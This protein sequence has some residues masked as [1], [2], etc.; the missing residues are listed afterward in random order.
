MD[1]PVAENTSSPG[2]PLP[3]AGES[4]WNRSSQKIDI[5]KLAEKVYQLMRAD[6]RQAGARGNT[7]RSRK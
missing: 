1:E 7:Y 4:D 5:E 6:L 2:L 3:V